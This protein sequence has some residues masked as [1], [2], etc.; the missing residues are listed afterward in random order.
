MILLS[1]NNDNCFLAIDLEG[2]IKEKEEKCKDLNNNIEEHT[3]FF[4]LKNLF[5]HLTIFLKISDSLRF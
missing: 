4:F 5:F 1:D 3:D 2:K